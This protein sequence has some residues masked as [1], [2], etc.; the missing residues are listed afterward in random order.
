MRH[1]SCSG[2][3]SISYFINSKFTAFTNFSFQSYKQWQSHTQRPANN[4]TAGVQANLLD[5]RLS[6]S[7]VA[8]DLLHRAHYNNLT[9]FYRNTRNGTRG[10]NDM[11]GI[12]LTVS[13]SLFNQNLNDV[14]ASR[15]DSDIIERTK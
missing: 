11:R 3:M 15:G 6:M 8:S 14:K 9:Y 10:T 2:N 12:S 1:A 13:Y 5:G 7:L 4:W